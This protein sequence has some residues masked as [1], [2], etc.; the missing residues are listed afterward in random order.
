MDSY[1]LKSV[2]EFPGFFKG[3]TPGSIEADGKPSEAKEK[4]PIKISKVS[5]GS[6]NMITGKNNELPKTSRASANGVYSKSSYSSICR[7]S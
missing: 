2:A 4:L 5:L 6:L 7:L 3:N 1:T